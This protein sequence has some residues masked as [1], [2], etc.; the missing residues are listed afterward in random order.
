VQK[1]VLPEKRNP[2]KRRGKELGKNVCQNHVRASSGGGGIEN[3]ARAV[4]AIRATQPQ[5]KAWGV[6]ESPSCLSRRQ[7]TQEHTYQPSGPSRTKNTRQSTG[8][9]QACLKKPRRPFDIGC[10]AAARE[11]NR[12]KVSIAKGRQKLQ[13]VETGSNRGSVTMC[14]GCRGGG[15]VGR[16][17]TLEKDRRI[18]VLL[19]VE[20]LLSRYSE[21]EKKKKTASHATT[22][23]QKFGTAIFKKVC[24]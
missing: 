4:R 5:G 22:R 19:C 1:P 18:G 9:A 10:G 16:K 2:H 8:A 6:W 17:R 14:G 13:D 23:P 15:G 7:S 20:I 24:T 12:Q 21:E 11:N 3:V